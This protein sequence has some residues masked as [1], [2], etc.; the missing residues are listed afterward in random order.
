MYLPREKE[1]EEIGAG[2]E[3]TGEAH[4]IGP[5]GARLIH[6]REQ[7]NCIVGVSGRGVGG[8]DGIPSA[9]ISPGHFVEQLTSIAEAATSRVSL[10]GAVEKEG[11]RVAGMVGGDDV[12]LEVASVDEG[13]GG[14]GDAEEAGVERDRERG[15][16]GEEGGEGCGEVV[17]IDVVENEGGRGRGLGGF[18]WTG[19]ILEKAI[20]DGGGAAC[21]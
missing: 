6:P 15:G 17:G 8:D 13:A 10:D 5:G 9:A 20:E 2:A 1:R 21:H 19:G 16:D 11:G 7:E 14:G 12:G 4:V 18:L 3:R